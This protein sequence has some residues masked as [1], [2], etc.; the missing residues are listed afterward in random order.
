MGGFSFK[1][2]KCLSINDLQRRARPGGV[3][4][5]ASTTYRS[6]SSVLLGRVKQKTRRKILQFFRGWHAFRSP[7]RAVPSA[8]F[9]RL[10]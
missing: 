9:P 10:A 1:T 6:D 5:S 2:C 3:T 4:P 7:A 8:I